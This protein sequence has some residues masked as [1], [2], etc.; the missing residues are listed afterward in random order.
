MLL[1]LKRER[2]FVDA[3]K[4]LEIIF[5]LPILMISV[6]TDGYREDFET[7]IQRRRHPEGEEAM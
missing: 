4:H 2:V 5:G 1:Y 7:D 6:L 3:V